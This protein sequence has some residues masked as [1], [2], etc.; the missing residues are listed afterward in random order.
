MEAWRG[1][2]AYSWSWT[3]H[4]ESWNGLL[5]R[6]K[7]SLS[8][9]DPDICF[10]FPKGILDRH[11]IWLCNYPAIIH[12]I[13]ISSYPGS[14]S[15]IGWSEVSVQGLSFFVIQLIL[16]FRHLAFFFSFCHTSTTLHANIDARLVHLKFL[17][18]RKQETHW[19]NFYEVKIICISSGPR[20]NTWVYKTLTCHCEDS[21]Q[22]YFCKIENYWLLYQFPLLWF[23]INSILVNHLHFLALIW[24]RKLIFLMK[25]LIVRWFFN[26]LFNYFEREVYR[27]FDIWLLAFLIRFK[28]FS[29]SK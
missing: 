8:S 2:G 9:N 24:P 20:R 7:V 13:E 6:S 11:N 22:N 12:L 27:N 15:H 19:L 1:K 26:Q 21:C 29:F 5:G 10:H 25:Q 16:T 14:E 3:S 4:Q 17:Q 28:I 23:E 18:N